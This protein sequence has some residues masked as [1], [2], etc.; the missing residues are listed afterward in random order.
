VFLIMCFVIIM[1]FFTIMLF[2]TGERAF[3]PSE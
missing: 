1:P 2:I 3:I